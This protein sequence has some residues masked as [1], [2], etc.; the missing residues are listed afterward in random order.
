MANLR[1]NRVLCFSR[2]KSYARHKLASK[3]CSCAFLGYSTQHNA[4]KCFDENITEVM[5]FSMELDFLS[6]P[7]HQQFT[8]TTS[9]LFY[10]SVNPILHSRMKQYIYLIFHFVQDKV[11]NSL[12]QIVMSPQKINSGQDWS[13]IPSREGVIQR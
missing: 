8:A 13:V 4:R 3:S 11:P 9:E 7:H 10:L 1:S 5:S 12:L 2:S 6:P